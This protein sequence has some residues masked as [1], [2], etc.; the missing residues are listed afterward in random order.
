M[1]NHY[2]AAVAAVFG[3][4][5]VADIAVYELPDVHGRQGCWI[6]VIYRGLD[7]GPDA[8][9]MRRVM[10]CVGDVA[11]AADP[12]PVVSFV[13]EADMIQIAAE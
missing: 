7:T 1:T 12:R 10:D 6:E 4:D 5:H 8:D 11:C 3:R 2:E 13:S 9:L